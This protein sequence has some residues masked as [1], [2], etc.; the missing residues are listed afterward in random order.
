MSS[1]HSPSNGEL[2]TT[3]PR[4]RTQ[5]TWNQ[6]LGQ[7]Q[8]N[9]LIDRRTSQGRNEVSNISRERSTSGLRDLS[10]ELKKDNYRPLGSGAG[11]GDV[12]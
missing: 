8:V 10:I 6:N 3:V 4:P 12:N 1:M 11:I 7:P 9:N 2:I 5:S